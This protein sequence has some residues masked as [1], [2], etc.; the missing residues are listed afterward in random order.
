MKIIVFFLLIIGFN[1]TFF[2]NPI[3]AQVS[4]YP[5]SLLEDNKLL[6]KNDD[7]LVVY[8]T[9]IPNKDS[10]LSIEEILNQDGKIRPQLY[11]YA[12]EVNLNTQNSG[13]W[14]TLK[15]GDRIW[16]LRAVCPDAYCCSGSSVIIINETNELKKENGK[17]QKGVIL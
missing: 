5:R 3:I 2:L 7:E 13:I 9:S 11:G 4:F 15:N 10:L 6:L 1:V 16:R 17:Y 8:S 14:E 12:Y